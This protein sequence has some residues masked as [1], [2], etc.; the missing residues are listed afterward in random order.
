MTSA[1]RALLNHFRQLNPAQ[2]QTAQ[3]FLAF[4]ASRPQ[5]FV[6]EDMPQ[7]VEIPRP[8]QESVVKAIKRLRATYP[9]LEPNKL[10]NDTSNQMSRHMIHSVPAVEVIDELELVFKRHYEA[11]VIKFLPS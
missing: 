11:H 6:A 1:E 7:P 2:Q 8:E 4:L 9:M 10:L 3:D 5:E